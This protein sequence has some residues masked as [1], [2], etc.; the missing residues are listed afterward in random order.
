MLIIFLF[1]GIQLIFILSSILINYLLFQDFF[2]LS[3]DGYFYFIITLINY[4]LFLTIFINWLA[5]SHGNF[6]KFIFQAEIPNSLFLG[7]NNKFRLLRNKEP[8]SIKGI[9]LFS[10]V[11]IV[12]LII[13]FGVIVFFYRNQRLIYSNEIIDALEYLTP[14]IL[15]WI[16]IVNISFIILAIIVFIF[17]IKRLKAF[18]DHKIYIPEDL[19]NFV[20]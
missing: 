15:N 2:I 8:L 5:L 14:I 4:N 1:F 18:P 12:V 10:F 7:S 3:F 19:K 6:R 13:V 9:F 16:V 20:R 17:T 11:Q